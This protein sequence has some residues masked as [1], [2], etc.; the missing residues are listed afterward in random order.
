MERRGGGGAGLG[1]GNGNTRLDATKKGTG[2]GAEKAIHPDKAGDL[3]YRFKGFLPQINYG[4]DDTKD[5][6]A[7]LRQ[8]VACKFGTHCKFLHTAI[9]SMSADKQKWWYQLVLDTENLD[10]DWARMPKS[11][12]PLAFQH[13]NPVAPAAPS[14]P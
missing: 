3:I 14:I 2:A 10:F 13:T 6:S 4:A 8:G 1:G 5:C 12:F 7:F 9:A 11:T